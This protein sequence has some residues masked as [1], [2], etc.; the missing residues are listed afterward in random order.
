MRLRGY[1]EQAITETKN[2][3]MNLWLKFNLRALDYR[4]KYDVP[5]K[6]K[7]PDSST[8]SES[9]I[10]SIEADGGGIVIDSDGEEG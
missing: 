2:D 10:A 6:F 8:L 5:D 4:T 1:E 3:E 7:E 9:E